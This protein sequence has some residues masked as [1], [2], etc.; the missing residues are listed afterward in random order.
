MNIEIMTCCRRATE[1]RGALNLEETFDS[2]SVAKTP[3]ELHPFAI[4]I[5]FRALEAMVNPQ[6]VF[7]GL[8]PVGE[9]MFKTPNVY[10]ACQVPPGASITYVFQVGRMRVTR[11]GVYRIQAEVDDQM[12]AELPLYVHLVGQHQRSRKSGFDVALN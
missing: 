8:N 5:R 12:I 4:A 3:V 6:L 2:F 7:K 9:E 10:P 1:I 11:A